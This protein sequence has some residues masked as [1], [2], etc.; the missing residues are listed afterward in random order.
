VEHDIEVPSL[1]V[2]RPS[3]EDTYLALVAAHDAD[4]ATEEAAR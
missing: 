1:S 4:G 3:L 2:G